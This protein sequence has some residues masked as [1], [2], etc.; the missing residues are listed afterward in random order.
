MSVEIETPMTFKD[1]VFMSQ[2]LI[3]ESDTNL[4]LE[5]GEKLFEHPQFYKDCCNVYF[6]GQTVENAA[7]KFK[8]DSLWATF[9]PNW[10]K[11]FGKIVIRKNTEDVFITRNEKLA[12][13][14]LNQQKI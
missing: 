8:K 2:K 10:S 7:K 13:Q 14:I 9:H 3:G 6:M 4:Y 1:Y 12:L 5:S 11:D